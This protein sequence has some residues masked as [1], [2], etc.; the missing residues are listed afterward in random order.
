MGH[1]DISSNASVVSDHCGEGG[2]EPQGKAFDLLVN[3]HFN[4]WSQSLDRA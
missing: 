2:A 1:Y 4:I 3:L